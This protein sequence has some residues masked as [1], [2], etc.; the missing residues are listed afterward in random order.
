MTR[1]ISKLFNGSDIGL[2]LGRPDNNP[3]AAHG[4]KEND[5]RTDTGLFSPKNPVSVPG[6]LYKRGITK[7]N[8]TYEIKVI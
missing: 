1:D 6:T 5:P 7:A 3:C 8:H 2:L 4:G